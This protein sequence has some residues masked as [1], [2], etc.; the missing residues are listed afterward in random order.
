MA[1]PSVR[2][3]VTWVDQL[4]TAKVRFVKFSAYGSPMGP[5]SGVVKQGRVGKTSH[6]LA[7][8][9]NISK[10]EGDTSKFFQVIIAFALS[11]DTI[12]DLDL[13]GL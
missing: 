6:F 10:T 9:I 7:L 5:Q 1:R 4:K 13:L 8:N 2:L 3:S 11:T 12:D